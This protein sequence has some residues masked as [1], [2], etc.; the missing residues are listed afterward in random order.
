MSLAVHAKNGKQHSK[1]VASV[2]D[3]APGRVHASYMSFVQDVE[4]QG[5][6]RQPKITFLFKL[7]PGIADRSFGLN[8]ARMAHLPA[9]VVQR[10]AVKAAEM[11]EEVTG[12]RYTS[13]EVLTHD[14]S[15]M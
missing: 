2:I 7:V 11:E 3:D 1:Q 4:P 14:N 12:V 15:P 8:V 5:D 10:A 9:K 6:E 13:A